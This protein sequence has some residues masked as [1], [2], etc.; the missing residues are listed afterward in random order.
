MH[1]LHPE[2]AS[3]VA[4]HFAFP[5]WEDQAPALPLNSAQ[6]LSLFEMRHSF[7]HHH[8][9]LEVLLRPLTLMYVHVL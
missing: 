8:A 6:E 7:D 5:D 1:S 4:G 3:G 9:L 2:N